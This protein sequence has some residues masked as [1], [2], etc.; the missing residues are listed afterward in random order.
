LNVSFSQEAENDWKS[1]DREMR[2][3]VEIDKLADSQKDK[4]KSKSKTYFVTLM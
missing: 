3:K 1:S 2:V 4:R